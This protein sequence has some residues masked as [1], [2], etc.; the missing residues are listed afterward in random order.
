MKRHGVQFP[1][2]VLVLLGLTV[3]LY[4]MAG[5]IGKIHTWEVIWD[6]PTVS[7][8]LS[9]LVA[10]LVA[11]LAGCGVDVTVIGKSLLQLI[12]VQVWSSAEPDPVV[13]LADLA[14]LGVPVIPVV[15]TNKG[16]KV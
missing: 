3:F 5:V 10:G 14:D 6:P 13:P 7:E 8:M 15:P 16:E 1:L 4:Q 11:I 9:A 2:A 12:G